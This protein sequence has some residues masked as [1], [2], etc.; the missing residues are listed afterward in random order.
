MT[1]TPLLISGP[2]TGEEEERL[3]NACPSVR[4]ATLDA[5]GGLSEAARGGIRA[6]AFKGH[7]R[8]GGAV[9]DLL[10]NLGVIAN[11]GVGYDAIDVSAAS[12]RGVKVTNT[13]DVLNDDV[14]DLAVGLAL[15]FFRRMV[16]GADWVASGQW[17]TK[18][19]MPLNRKLSGSKV[20]IM[21]LGRIGREIADR[22]AAF[23]C[24]LHYHARSEKE[25]PGWTFHADPVG[26]ARAVD[27]LV[28]ALVGGDQT[29]NYVSREVIAALGDRG[30]IVNISRGTTIDEGALLDA[31]E[32]GAI[33]GAALDVFL[34]EPNI[35]PRFL[36]LENVV[37]QPHQGSGTVETRRAMAELQLENVR[38][39]LEGRPL[40]TPVN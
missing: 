8:F 14:A 6:V 12:E 29:R 24:E 39:F 3:K 2:F 34:N 16:V 18:G 26:L 36:E 31:L 22:F 21:G 25:T 10:P 40:A 4:V 17:P 7:N 38:N 11:F 30:V 9:M 27:V 37:L 1:D 5:V 33:A 19:E 13:P 28:V 32:S 35:D 15:T 23:K 20:G